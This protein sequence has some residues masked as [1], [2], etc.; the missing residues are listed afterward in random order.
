[1]RKLILSFVMLT[2][3]F[4]MLVA[5]DKPN[6]R[7]R[8]YDEKI[9]QNFRQPFRMP[10]T[11]SPEMGRKNAISEIE[12]EV[13]DG[14]NEQFVAI[15]NLL[16]GYTLQMRPDSYIL[17]YYDDAVPEWY[18]VYKQEISYHPNGKPEVTQYSYWDKNE[19]EWIYSGTIECDYYPNFLIQQVTQFEVNNPEPVSIAE[20]IY[21]PQ[22]KIDY[23]IKTAGADMST[24]VTRDK[25]FYDDN[26]RVSYTI[27]QE[28]DINQQWVDIVKTVISYLPQDISTYEDFANLYLLNLVWGVE[29]LNPYANVFKLQREDYYFRNA[30][31]WEFGYYRT[32]NYND[33]MQIQDTADWGY[34]NEWIET[35]KYVY[36]YDSSDY[37]QYMHYYVGDD[38]GLFLQHRLVY[39]Y[40]NFTANDDPVI[41]AARPGLSISPNP[42]SAGTTLSYKLTQSS[43]VEISIYNLKGQLIRTIFQE[44]KMAGDYTTGWD[45]LD[46]RGNSIGSGIFIVRLKTAGGIR[47]AK[48]ILLK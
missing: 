21:T 41:P 39:Y 42:F 48:A 45:G 11:F 33:I 43:P 12:M 32:F 30:L 35:H 7:F 34:M 1:M 10:K 16:V 46:D 3:V 40:D 44:T 31:D 27:F 6:P 29:N 4:S 15:E 5:T 36:S 23:I 8:R 18:L 2:I 37:M 28:L 24:F 38:L 26:G 47:S 17:S 19:K 22:N 25:I 14:W 13:W 20:F 9:R